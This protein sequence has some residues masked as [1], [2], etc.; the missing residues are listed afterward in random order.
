MVNVAICPNSNVPATK[1][2][3]IWFR[4]I[5]IG[6]LE[7][8]H[9]KTMKS[10]AMANRIP[11]TA[12]GGSPIELSSENRLYLAATGFPPQQA[13]IKTTKATAVKLRA[14]LLESWAVGSTEVNLPLSFIALNYERKRA[15]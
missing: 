12:S 10:V 5:L 15:S 8:R 4:G 11:L 14:G 6:A 3:R 7:T 2:G 13:A 9:Q 1:Q